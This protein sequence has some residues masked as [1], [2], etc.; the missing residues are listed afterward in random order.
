MEAHI[1]EDSQL[2]DGLQ[3]EEPGADV[4]SSFSHRP[5][6]LSD[7]LGGVESNLYYVIQ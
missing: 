2:G 3:Y 7:E 5:L 4:L 6:P 1:E